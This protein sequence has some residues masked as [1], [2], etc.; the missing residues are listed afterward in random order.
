MV[1][2]TCRRFWFLIIYLEFKVILVSV[3]WLLSPF[4]KTLWIELFLC[5]LLPNLDSCGDFSQIQRGLVIYVCFFKGADKELLPKMGMCFL[6]SHR[7]RGMGMSCWDSLWCRSV[8]VQRW[9][10]EWAN[11]QTVQAPLCCVGGF[12][13]VFNGLGLNLGLVLSKCSATDL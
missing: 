4:L 3:S 5:R 11:E 1:I 9:D 12:C 7:E 13:F 6:S 8:K 2:K 10:H